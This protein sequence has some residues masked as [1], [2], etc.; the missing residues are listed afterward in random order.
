MAGFGARN[1]DKHRANA[2]KVN[3]WHRDADKNRGEEE[4]NVLQC[5]DPR[6]SPNP[7]GEYKAGDNGE[8][9]HHGRRAM[10]HSETRHFHNDPETSDLK[11]QIRDDEDH[12]HKGNEGGEILVL[13]AYLKEI[14]LCLEAIPPP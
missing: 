5:T 12:A 6:H 8:G 10:D 2:S 3:V 4:N 13:V 14:G 7:A 9:D 1:R 11:L